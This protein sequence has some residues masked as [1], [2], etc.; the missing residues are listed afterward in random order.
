MWTL[1]M[2]VWI[3]NQLSKLSRLRLLNYDLQ[4]DRTYYCNVHYPGGR[5]PHI[6]L[7][8]CQR[9]TYV[10]LSVFG[11][12]VSVCLYVYKFRKFPQLQICRSH[13]PK[14]GLKLA[15]CKRPNSTTSPQTIHS[16]WERDN[17]AMPHLAGFV[18]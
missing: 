1:L 4:A 13:M 10:C 14:H 3:L 11:T 16:M 18:G 6:S 2:C 15:S 5:A 8:A 7:F 9:L 12:C 17:H